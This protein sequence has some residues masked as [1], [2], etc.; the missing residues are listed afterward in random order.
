[1]TGCLG[2]PKDPMVPNTLVVN[3]SKKSDQIIGLSSRTA[4]AESGAVM[5]RSGCFL[6][7]HVG[8]YRWEVEGKKTHEIATTEFLQNLALKASLKHLK[9]PPSID[10]ACVVTLLSFLAAK[11]TTIAD[12]LVPG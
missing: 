10:P 9:Q 8:I 7:S 2:F 12:A 1:M 11:A 6:A 4:S 3:S 5:S